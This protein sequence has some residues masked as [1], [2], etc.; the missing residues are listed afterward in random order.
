MPR[1]Q[2]RCPAP[3]CDQITPCPD[4]TP[5]REAPAQRGYGHAHDKR[6][7]ALRQTSA[8][9]RAPCSL[10]G[11]AIDYQL[12][13]P[14]PWSFVA[15]HLTR[16]KGGPIAPAHRRCNERHGKPSTPPPPRG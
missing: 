2:R 3:A 5:T 14:H 16:D 8:K 9:H 12:R 7:A 15:H 4:H 11:Q 6:A 1:A 10:C 13:R